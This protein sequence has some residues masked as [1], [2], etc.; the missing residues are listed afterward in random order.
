M[1]VAELIA[2]LQELPQELEVFYV[3]EEHLL[4][5]LDEGAGVRVA[6]SSDMEYAYGWHVSHD[7]LADRIVILG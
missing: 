1:T 7:E 3:G 2:K 6:D 4:W 5:S